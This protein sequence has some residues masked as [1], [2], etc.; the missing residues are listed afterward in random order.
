MQGVA[1]WQVNAVMV[2]VI[3]RNRVSEK[4]RGRFAIVMHVAHGIALGV[5]LLFILLYIQVSRFLSVLGLAIVYSV[6]LW[7]ISP[8]VTRR[9]YE[10]RGNIRMTPRGLTVS[11]GSHII[12]GL[13]LGFLAAQ[14]V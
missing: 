6:V 9:V 3:S 14:I 7:I 2:A 11:F 13:V 12:Y 4:L 5:V 1:E 10:S 8:W